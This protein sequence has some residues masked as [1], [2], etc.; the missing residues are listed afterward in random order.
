MQKKLSAVIFAG[1]IWGIAEATIGWVLH[2]LHVHPMLLW[3]SPVVIACIWL[4][5]KATGSAWSVFYAALIAALI[6]CTDFLIPIDVPAYWVLNPAMYIAA[7]GLVGALII[8]VFNF[9]QLPKFRFN[10]TNAVAGITLLLSIAV[11]LV[12]FIWR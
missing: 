2:M 9:K 10:L 7:E 6:K 5:Y 12:L 4:A 1:A 11:N 3:M 8:K